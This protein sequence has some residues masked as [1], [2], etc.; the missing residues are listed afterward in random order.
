MA[1]INHSSWSWIYGIA[2]GAA[3]LLGYK[4]TR[5]KGTEPQQSGSN[6]GSRSNREGRQPETVDAKIPPLASAEQ[7]AVA[8]GRLIDAMIQPR[9]CYMESLDYAVRD[10]DFL[11]AVLAKLLGQST[12]AEVA[13]DERELQN[14]LREAP[15]IYAAQLQTP[16]GLLRL[17]NVV[18]Q[19]FARPLVRTSGKLVE[20]DYGHI[21]AK[22]RIN[23]RH[24]I[25][26]DF[27][28][29][30]HLVDREWRSSEVAAALKEH[31]AQHP[32]V[33]G[34]QLRVVIPEALLAN[35][36]QYSY[37]RSTDRVQVSFPGAPRRP[38]ISAELHHDFGP[39]VRGEKSLA[40]RDLQMVNPAIMQPVGGAEPPARE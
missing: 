21:A 8:R 4:V 5:N 28:L 11:E 7:L 13:G 20:V 25:G 12:L 19:R 6:S 38:F 34:V 33:E 2:I 40:T 29:S 22:L 1:E 14:L 23:R 26:I 35:E 27:E 30:P 32:D 9:S 18:A 10:P 36:W 17:E 37:R 15:A 24:T 3:V 39:Y 16:D 31:L